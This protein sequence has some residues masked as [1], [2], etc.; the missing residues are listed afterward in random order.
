MKESKSIFIILVFKSAKS[1]ISLSFLFS[2]KTFSFWQLFRVKLSCSPK[3][4]YTTS[5]PWQWWWFM[6]IFFSLL[7]VLFRT[8]NTTRFRVVHC[9]VCLYVCSNF[10]FPFTPCFLLPDDVHFHTFFFSCCFEKVVDN[11]LHRKI[12]RYVQTLLNWNP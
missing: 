12:L 3:S 2:K 9:Y 1:F 5:V 10:V 8:Q 6:L 7:P 11:G 4:F